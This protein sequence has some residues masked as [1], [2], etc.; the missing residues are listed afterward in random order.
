LSDVPRLTEL[1]AELVRRRVTSYPGQ[2]RQS[3]SI[4]AGLSRAKSRPTCR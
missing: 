2:A 4:S 1:A 3:A